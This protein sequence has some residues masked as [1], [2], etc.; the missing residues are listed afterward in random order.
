M[1]KCSFLLLLST[2]AQLVALRCTAREAALTAQ[3]EHDLSSRTASL[4][5]MRLFSAVSHLSLL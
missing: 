4:G 3:G 1:Q 2:S 5:I